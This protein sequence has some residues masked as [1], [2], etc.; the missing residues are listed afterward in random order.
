MSGCQ[1]R[2]FA[3]AHRFL[4]MHS[5]VITDEDDTSKSSLAA[6]TAPPPHQLFACQPP[7]WLVRIEGPAGRGTIGKLVRSGG[8]E[9]GVLHGIQ[10]G[11]SPAPLRGWLLTAL[12]PLILAGPAGAEIND[13]RFFGRDS[14]VQQ[15]LASRLSLRWE[16]VPLGDA[17]QRLADTQGVAIWLDRRAD[18]SI[19]VTLAVRDVTLHDLLVDLAGKTGLGFTAARGVVFIGP[20]E[21]AAELRTLWAVAQGQVDRMPA[22][23]RAQMLRSTSLDL[24][25]L[26][27]PRDVVIALAKRMGTPIEN[28]EAVPHDLWPARQL[29]PMA[30]VDQLTLLLAGFDLTWQPGRDKSRLRLIPIERPVVVGRQYERPTNSRLV[31]LQNS[32]AVVETIGRGGAVRV[33]G[34]VEQHELLRGEDRKVA[35]SRQPRRPGRQVYTLRVQEQ[36]AQAILEHLARQ[37]GKR[38][39]LDAPLQKDASLLQQR[40]TFEV[41]EVGLDELLDAIAA[42][43]GL[44]IRSENDAITVSVI[45]AE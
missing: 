32:G 41:R 23:V 4:P 18:S 14:V 9:A 11:R 2:G 33:A 30:A 20:Q 25:R 37:L 42:P 31:Q 7:W 34:R 15:R 24:P 12:L 39:L 17:V 21:A 8:V 13:A 35:P 43:V 27:E 29:P 1:S 44:E 26:V 28:P 19:E 5:S 22:S 45:S 6:A 10:L 40:V 38:L 36:P 16:G 3:T